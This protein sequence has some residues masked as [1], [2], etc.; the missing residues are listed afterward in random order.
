MMVRLVGQYQQNLAVVGGLSISRFRNLRPWALWKT[1]EPI[2]RL[3]FAT[4]STKWFIGVP[5][6][7][8]RGLMYGHGFASLFAG[9]WRDSSAG[10]A[11]CIN[12]CHRVNRFDSERRRWLAIRTQKDADIS[13]TV[14]QTMALRAAQC[15]VFCPRKNSDACSELCPEFANADGGFRCTAE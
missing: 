12:E 10:S 13:V 7:G 9:V 2:G 11:S 1:C 14:C 4:C 15:R 3:C 5:D 8:V 6:R